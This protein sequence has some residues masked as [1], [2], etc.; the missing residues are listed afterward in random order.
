M[1]KK[2]VVQL[3][4]D[5]MGEVQTEHPDLELVLSYSGEIIVQGAVR[6]SINLK[7]NTVKDEY[8]IE[9]VIPTDYPDSPPTAR[10]TGNAIPDN[11]HKFI[12]SGNLCLGAPIEVRRAFAQHKTLLGFINLQVIPFLFSYSY[13]RDYGELPYGELAHGT[14]GLLD[15][16]STFFSVD[17]IKTMKLL[18]LLADDFAPPLMK[19]PCDSGKSLQDCH[20]HKLDELRP[21]YPPQAFAAELRN[22]ITEAQKLGIHLPERDVMPR[23]MWKRRENRRRKELRHK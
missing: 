20:R 19:C 4:A 9:M 16:Y 23:R 6:F 11:F 7:G 14:P 10:E 2:E 21:Y 5:Q 18:K 8:H 12:K 22:M 3:V 15:Y 13:F 1:H 17:F